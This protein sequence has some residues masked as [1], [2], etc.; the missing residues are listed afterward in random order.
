M[1][2]KRFEV[3][4]SFRGIAALSVV[5]FHMHYIGS[6]TELGFFRGS[7]LFVEFFFVLSGFVL[8]HGYTFR[9]I[10][11]K[12]FA[13]ARTFRLM[14]LHIFMLGIFIMFEFGKT[15]AFNYGFNFNN[16]P[17]TNSAAVKEIIPNLLLLQ[18]WLPFS[19][20]LSWNYPS[21][22]ISVEYYMYMIFFIT[23]FTNRLKYIVWFLISIISFLFIANNTDILSSVLRGLS[24][25]F[26]GALV[27]ILYLKT[28]DKFNKLQDTTFF[29]LEIL[30]I[31]LSIYLI[32]LEKFEYKSISVSILFMMNVYVF[33]FE[34]S[35]I[36]ILLKKS[37]FQLLGKL[38]YSIYM[39][40]AAILFVALSSIMILEKIL[41]IKL[42]VMIGDVRNI[43]FGSILLN[44]AVII[45]VLLI[46]I[47]VSIFTHKFIE[48]K[49][50]KIG[51]KLI[52]K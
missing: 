37:F 31:A 21:W 35:I 30:L 10:S 6:I 34:R 19:K 45:L 11:F 49:G 23:L 17:F 48:L 51:K 46:V 7:Y 18:T 38:S 4:D 41:K 8:A 36:S 16:E 52:S 32:S 40:H 33:S 42:T 14:P 5:V 27:Y 13:I 25:F 26:A 20:D 24:S 12:N 22:S 43:D 15:L 44:N 50:Q 1:S 2:N 3:L 47:V 29:I 9:R 39:T 28:N